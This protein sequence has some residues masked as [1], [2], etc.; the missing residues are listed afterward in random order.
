MKYDTDQCNIKNLL[1][2]PNNYRFLDLEDYQEVSE[3]RYHEKT[4]QDRAYRFLRGKRYEDLEALKDSILRNGYVPL[5]HLIVKRYDIERDYFVV[6]EGNRRVAAMRW[7]LEDEE[8]GVDVSKSLIQSFSCLPII[9]IDIKEPENVDAIPVLMG[10][11]HVSGIR[12]WGAYQQAKLVSQLVEDFHLSLQETAERLAMS[13]RE[14]NRRRRAYKALEQMQKDESFQ[15][16]ADPELYY[17]FHEAI[18]IPEVRNWLGWSE[19]DLKFTNEE[20][21]AQFYELIVPRSDE[22]G[23]PAPAKLQTREDVSNLK[24]ILRDENAK[25]ALLDPL[26]T[27]NEALALAIATESGGWVS[28][29]RSAINAIEGIKIKDI[30]LITSDEIELMEKLRNLLNERIEDRK[31]LS[32]K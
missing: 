10:I 13:T 2:D 6:I 26:K 15:N 1:L 5:E 12:P 3:K 24:R 32:Q 29:V 31:K 30:K 8:S 4:V 14:A 23:H 7:I 19:P 11:R 27:Y 22:E 21:R 28:Q 16:L 20:N 9:I 17:K 18:G 25:A